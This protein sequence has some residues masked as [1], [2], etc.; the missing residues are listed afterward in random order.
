MFGQ[1]ERNV[2][3]ILVNNKELKKGKKKRL[4]SITKRDLCQPFK[5]VLMSEIQLR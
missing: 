5:V 4:Y 2:K 1:A 3:S